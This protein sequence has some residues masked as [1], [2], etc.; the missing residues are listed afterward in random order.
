MKVFMVKGIEK[1]REKEKE[2]IAKRA[3]EKGQP[4]KL[5][6]EITKLSIEKIKALLKQ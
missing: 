1:G 5:I 2:E 3:Y 4:I 6:A